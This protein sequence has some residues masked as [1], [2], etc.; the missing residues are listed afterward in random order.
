MAASTS[1]ALRKSIGPLNRHLTEACS[2]AKIE[3]NK[4]VP[5]DVSVSQAEQIIAAFEGHV[6]KIE[7]KLESLNQRDEKWL[8]LIQSI[9]LQKE[10]EAETELYENFA[11]IENGYQA[12][13]EQAKELIAL[14]NLRLK[15]LHQIVK[16]ATGV[17]A[18]SEVSGS[19]TSV[20][21]TTTCASGS[22]S[23]RI[24]KVDLPIFDG[25]VLKWKSFWAYFKCSI[26]D[27]ASLI[28][29]QKLTYLQAHVKGTAF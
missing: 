2:K 19:G 9:E 6:I 7:T 25:D 27:N 10:R 22:S 15:K 29:V 11:L 8:V 13:M 17:T 12:N 14:M 24:P 26:H 5:E 4:K 16:P 3:L 20:R 18:V 1:G 23:I 21:S 28:G